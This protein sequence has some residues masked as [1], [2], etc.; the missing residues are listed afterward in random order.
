MIYQLVKNTEIVDPNLGTFQSAMFS[1]TLSVQTV[2][3]HVLSFELASLRDV[4]LGYDL[5]ENMKLVR[6]AADYDP[7]LENM[8]LTNLAYNKLWET[9]LKNYY[10]LAFSAEMQAKLTSQI[11][12]AGV[13]QLN[14][15]LYKPVTDE[16]RKEKFISVRGSVSV[17]RSETLNYLCRNKADFPLWENTE[18][19]K[20]ACGCDSETVKPAKKKTFLAFL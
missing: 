19:A 5:Y 4:I 7:T 3:P 16:T 17:L 9:V 14:G 20:S 8:F 2:A 6:N 1:D 15:S 12:D 13:V 18:I 10:H 11:G